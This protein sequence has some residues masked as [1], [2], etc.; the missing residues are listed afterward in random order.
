M[1]NETLT[2]DQA[3]KIDTAIAAFRA[4]LAAAEGNFTAFLV[5][6]DQITAVARGQCDKRPKEVMLFAEYLKNETIS[7]AYYLLYA[8]QNPLKWTTTELSLLQVAAEQC[9]VAMVAAV[10]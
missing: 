4:E 7:N 3:S 8:A 6:L 2:A 1:V 5:K 10:S 9:R